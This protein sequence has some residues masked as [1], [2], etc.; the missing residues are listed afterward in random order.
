MTPDATPKAPEPYSAP[1]RVR[2]GATEVVC[3][4]CGRWTAQ[5]DTVCAYC[6]GAL[7]NGEK[8]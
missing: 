7:D 8:K 6:K 4:H 2:D 1:R 5:A 3:R